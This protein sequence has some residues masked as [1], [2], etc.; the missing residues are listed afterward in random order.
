MRAFSNPA[1]GGYVGDQVLNA[2]Y[3]ALSRLDG[4]VTAGTGAFPERTVGRDDL[5][6]RT[7][8]GTLRL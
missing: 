3:E 1:Q 7:I 8:C 4:V 6:Y 5:L 2:G